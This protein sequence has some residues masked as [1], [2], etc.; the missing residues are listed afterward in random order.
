VCVS[1]R[2]KIRRQES[3]TRK[4][5]CNKHRV[6]SKKQHQDSRGQGY[7]GKAKIAIR[8]LKSIIKGG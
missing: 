4:V 3:A 5:M 7:E 6:P 1:V 8:N 2:L